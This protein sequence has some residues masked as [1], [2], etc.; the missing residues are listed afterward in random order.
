MY[1][2]MSVWFLGGEQQTF[3]DIFT[4]LFTILDVQYCFFSWA[5]S[6]KQQKLYYNIYIY[7]KYDFLKLLTCVPLTA[8]IVIYKT[9]F[10]FP[11]KV[12]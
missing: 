5:Q 11:V 3:Q 12:V 1:N 9:I 10:L 2:I 8:Q 4:L 6:S 7:I